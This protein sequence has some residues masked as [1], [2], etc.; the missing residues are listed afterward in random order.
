MN[1]LESNFEEFT[2]D[3]NKHINFKLSCH[4]LNKSINVLSY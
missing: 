3:A 4:F 2:C 1:L